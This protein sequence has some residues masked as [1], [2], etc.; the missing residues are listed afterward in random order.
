MQ[1]ACITGGNT[2][3]PRVLYCDYLPLALGSR[4]LD[5]VRRSVALDR[6]ACT[7]LLESGTYQF[8]TVDAPNVPD[9]ELKSAVRWRLKDLLDYPVE[10]ATVDVARIPPRDGGKARS[11]L[12]VAVQNDVLEAHTRRIVDADIPLK[13]VDVPEM[14]QRNLSALY[15]GG[16]GVALLAFDASGGLLTVSYGGELYMARRIDLTAGQLQDANVEL[17]REHF[18]RVA[19]ALQRSF[20]YADRQFGFIAIARLLLA[21]LADAVPLREH[22]GQSLGLPV[23]TLN[24]ATLL[25]VEA[26]PELLQ[27]DAQG[28]Y[29]HVLGAALRWEEGVAA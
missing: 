20:D 23:E 6:Y 9:A 13:A 14:A 12:A 1:V 29:F 4:G 21:P 25:D 26:V 27:T 11:L 3:K 7:T 2:K 18:D 5:G 15:D 24:L 8:L 17:R 22:L 16:Q 10:Q 28:D 19:L